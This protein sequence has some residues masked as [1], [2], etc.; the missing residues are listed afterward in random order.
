MAGPVDEMC[1]DMIDATLTCQEA[2]MEKG[3][4]RQKKL[5]KL[6]RKLEHVYTNLRQE[7]DKMEKE[8]GA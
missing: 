3:K 8:H 4:D 6:Q 2:A 7:L 1:R 5:V